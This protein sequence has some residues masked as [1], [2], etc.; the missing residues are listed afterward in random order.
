[1]YIIFI[2]L[3]YLLRL[4]ALKRANMGADA[5]YEGQYVLDE[6]L[7]VQWYI[8]VRPASELETGS[9]SML[10]REVHRVGTMT[11]CAE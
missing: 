5:K 3:Y 2:N 7:I 10:L 4:H 8:V 11:H 1:M 9:P 6:M